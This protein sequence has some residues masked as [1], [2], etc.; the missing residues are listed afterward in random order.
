MAEELE[1]P[2]QAKFQVRNIVKTEFEVRNL[3][4]EIRQCDGPL[5]V[6]NDFNTKIKMRINL[7]KSMIEVREK[8]LEIINNFVQFHL[9]CFMVELRVQNDD[10]Y[11][12]HTS[13]NPSPLGQQWF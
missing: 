1:V 11:V 2:I 6:L 7:L 3:V 8:S 5:T 4:Q 10:Y 13:H 9:N 12:H